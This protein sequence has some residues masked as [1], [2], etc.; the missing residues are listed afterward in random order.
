MDAAEMGLHSSR[1]LDARK[2]NKV[3]ASEAVPMLI[4]AQ[5]TQYTHLLTDALRLAC[6]S[7]DIYYIPRTRWTPQPIPVSNPL[8]K[9]SVQPRMGLLLYF[10]QIP[11]AVYLNSVQPYLP[12]ITVPLLSIL[13]CLDWCPK[14]A[15]K[16]PPVP[17]NWPCSL[18]RPSYAGSLCL[19]CPSYCA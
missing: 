19:Y 5:F 1:H 15:Y 16:C 6:T 12:G 18:Q 11:A 13:P 4:E 7:F 14:T 10:I 8:I 9:F 2:I 17:F 3:F